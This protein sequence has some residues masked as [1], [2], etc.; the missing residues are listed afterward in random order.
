MPI[1]EK[2]RQLQ[3]DLISCKSKHRV[4]AV[5]NRRL[6]SID[7]GSHL[8]TQNVFKVKKS[9]K[10]GVSDITQDFG[11]HHPKFPDFLNL[12]SLKFGR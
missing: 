7:L 2:M 12:I 3:N 1:P 10:S 8:V 11:L 5:Q 4:L 6:L 9:I